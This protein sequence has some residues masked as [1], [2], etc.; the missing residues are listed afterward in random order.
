MDAWFARNRLSAYLDGAL[1]PDEAAEVKQV[2]DADPAL[3]Q[4]LEAMQDAIVLVREQGRLR[5]PPDFHERVLSRI[6]LERPAAANTTRHFDRRRLW[7]GLAAAALLFVTLPAGLWWTASTRAPDAGLAEIAAA[8]PQPDAEMSIPAADVDPI[9]VIAPRS[10]SEEAK[11]AARELRSQRPEAPEIVSRGRSRVTGLPSDGT[12]SVPSWD[13]D[14]E[15]R[16]LLGQPDEAGVLAGGVHQRPSADWRITLA[17]ADVLFRLMEI[18]RSVGGELQDGRG[19]PLEVRELT[20]EQNS[21]RAQLVV[22]A[23]RKA[24]VEAA[25]ESLGAL[26]SR[27]LGDVNETETVVFRVDVQYEP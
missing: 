13:Q 19:R 18:N 11:L 8:G 26:E 21:A 1:P 12:Y 16:E 27:P 17:S 24:E 20:I 23:T 10:V 9:P 15:S 5:A 7:A 4:E 22:P 25:L 14:P 3:R 6:A 2:L